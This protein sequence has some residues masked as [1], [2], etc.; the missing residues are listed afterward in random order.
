[1]IYAI[2]RREDEHLFNKIMLLDRK[3]VTVEEL[4]R[5]EEYVTI[6]HAAVSHLNFFN[7]LTTLQICKFLFFYCRLLNYPI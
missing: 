3:N 7:N 1:M 4:G 6:I 2:N 5:S